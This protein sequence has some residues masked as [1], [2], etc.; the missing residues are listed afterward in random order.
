MAETVSPLDIKLRAFEVPLSS[1]S[2]PDQVFVGDGPTTGPK[3]FT[4]AVIVQDG[5]ARLATPNTPVPNLQNPRLS[6]L[7]GPL[8]N[9]T[10]ANYSLSDVVTGTSGLYLGT[11]NAPPLT[12]NFGQP[13]QPGHTYYNLN[14][15]VL[16]VWSS[17]GRW[18]PGGST[19]PV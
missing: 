6:V 1:R 15:Q 18:I 5:T 13:L 11:K 14:D 16:Y 4:P 3:S 19:F 8:D 10:V 9:P 12:D 2:G 17:S 7:S